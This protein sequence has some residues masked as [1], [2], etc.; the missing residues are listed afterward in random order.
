MAALKIILAILFILAGLALT[1]I[2]LMQEGKQQGLGAISG[3]AETYWGKN[4]GRSMEGILVKVTT[5][6]VVVFLL[7]SLLLNI[8]ALSL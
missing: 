6:L 4:K 2:V 7:V 5:A 8:P 3:A 1:V